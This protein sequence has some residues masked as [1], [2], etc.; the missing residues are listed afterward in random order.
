VGC[1]VEKGGGGGKGKRKIQKQRPIRQK[2]GG[3]NPWDWVRTRGLLTSGGGEK[4][5]AFMG[6]E[7]ARKREELEKI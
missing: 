6:V 1:G 2:K 3:A 5:K 4:W 7:K